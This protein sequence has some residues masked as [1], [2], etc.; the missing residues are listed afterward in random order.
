MDLLPLRVAYEVL[1]EI[2]EVYQ[3]LVHHL[4]GIVSHTHRGCF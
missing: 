1:C 2:S 3:A 4:Q